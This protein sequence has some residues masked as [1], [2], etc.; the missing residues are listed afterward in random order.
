MTTTLI[1]LSSVTKRFNDKLILENVSFT[2]HKGEIVTLIGQNGV[3]KTTLAKIIL[4]LE[5]PS[6]GSINKQKNLKIGYVPQKLDFDFT[7][8]LTSSALLNLL[9]P[10]GTNQKVIE[11]MHFVH[12]NDIKDKDIASISSGQ[13]Q[14]LLLLGVLMDQPDVII[15]DEPIQY[16]DVASQQAFYQI[17]NYLKQEWHLTVFMISHDLFTVMKNSDQ[18][19]CLNKHICCSGRPSDISSDKN[20]KNALSEIGVYI[21]DHD[22][23][24]D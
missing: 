14:K 3:G 15:L 4:G 21:H 1:E 19:I 7:M 5:T 18:V 2:I 10:N 13:L 22:H 8:P 20:F 17:L 23:M 11:L 9:S 6:S 12:Y 16:L 24:H